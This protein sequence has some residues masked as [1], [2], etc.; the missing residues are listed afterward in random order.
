MPPVKYWSFSLMTIFTRHAPPTRRSTSIGSDGSGM[1]GLKYH[2]RCAGSVQAWKTRS[3][4]A[5]RMRLSVN[6]RSTAFVAAIMLSPLW[7]RGSPRNGSMLWLAHGWR[8]ASPPMVPWFGRACSTC[9]MGGSILPLGNHRPQMLFE[10]VEAALEEGAIRL[11][12][13]LH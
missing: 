8:L 10:P 9:W 7:L 2:C 6:P 4:G 12:P 1:L 13:V 3:R 5:L 11:H